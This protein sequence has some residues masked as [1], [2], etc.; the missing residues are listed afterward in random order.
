MSLA[1]EIRKLATGRRPGEVYSFT[2]TRGQY[3][4]HQGDATYD[5]VLIEEGPGRWKTWVWEQK[6][7]NGK[8]IEPGPMNVPDRLLKPALV[9][10]TQDEIDK[11]VADGEEKWGVISEKRSERREKRNEQAEQ[12]HDKLVELGGGLKKGETCYW[13][14]GHRWSKGVWNG[15]T[16][17]GKA[18]MEVTPDFVVQWSGKAQAATVWVLMDRLHTLRGNYYNRVVGY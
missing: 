10:Y 12:K 8:W 14:S 17:G 15:D 6:A 13:P 3:R 16:N 4:N 1:N 7:T 9:Q 5:C 18:K 11:F 2:D